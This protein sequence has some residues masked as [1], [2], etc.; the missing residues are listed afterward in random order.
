MYLRCYSAL[1]AGA[2]LL[3]TVGCA[4][5]PHRVVYT[6]LNVRAARPALKV[7]P[8]KK[9]IQI[10]ERVEFETSKAELKKVSFHVLDQVAKVMSG[11]DAIKKVEVQGHTD[12]SGDA[13]KNMALSQARAE[14]V[15]KYLEGKG[16]APERLTAKGYGQT[17][18]VASNDTPEGRQQNRRVEFHIIEQ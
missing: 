10:G 1:T 9:I 15:K 8:M 16:I 14:S 13:A 2:A 12:S 6:P 4:A 7:V 3:L 18:A 17:K 11:N 5:P